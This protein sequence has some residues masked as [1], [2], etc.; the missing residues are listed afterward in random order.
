M[1]HVS[2]SQSPTFAPLHVLQTPSL[3]AHVLDLL[4][5]P[6]LIVLPTAL[7]LPVLE[8]LIE[9]GSSK[10]QPVIVVVGTPDEIERIKSLA[11]TAA[12][13]G[14]QV[15]GLR[16]LERV[17]DGVQDQD[18]DDDQEKSSNE[19]APVMKETDV[20]CIIWSRHG[21][22]DDQV[23][24]FHVFVPLLFRYGDK[25]PLNNLHVSSFRLLK[26]SRNLARVSSLI[27]T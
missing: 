6:S 7:L 27:A 21:N 17:G 14:I 25:L 13:N 12:Q 20:E 9:E 18:N 26:S 4:S 3:L 5:T 24:S 11:S 19:R 23:R 16:D 8:Q 15:V 2:I 22:N 10:L 1:L